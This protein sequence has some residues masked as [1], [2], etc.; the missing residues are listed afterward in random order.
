MAAVTRGQ[1]ARRRTT[2]RHCQAPPTEAR[3][4]LK[5]AKSRSGRR[6]AGGPTGFGGSDPVID[7][8]EAADCDRKGAGA[9]DRAAD[10]SSYFRAPKKRTPAHTGPAKA[11]TV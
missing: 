11:R 5:C 7:L 3:D 6:C 4:R 9:V 8:A 1:V 2:G 10:R